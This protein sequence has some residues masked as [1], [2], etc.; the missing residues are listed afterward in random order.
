MFAEGH[1]IGAILGGGNYA[2]TVIEQAAQYRDPSAAERLEL[3]LFDLKNWVTFA[4]AL[5]PALGAA[6]AGIRDTGDFVRF[7]KRLAKTAASLHDLQHDAARA[8]RKL[9]LE[10]TGDV[11]LSTAQVL[12]EDLTA[13]QSVYGHKRL[14]LPA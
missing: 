3:C 12:T 14:Q 9:M 7:S 13:R 2:R 4:A 8:K 5:L 1:N 6:L 11:L 10:V